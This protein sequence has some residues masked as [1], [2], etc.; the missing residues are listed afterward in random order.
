MM[1]LPW[2]CL[3]TTFIDARTHGNLPSE[4]AGMTCTS[5]MPRTSF[6]ERSISGTRLAVET[7]VSLSSRKA[8]VPY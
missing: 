7:S 5:V 3:S 1:D 4:P 6:V 2:D 8:S